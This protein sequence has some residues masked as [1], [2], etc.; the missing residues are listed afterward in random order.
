MGHCKEK[1]NMTSTR[2]LYVVFGLIYIV[3]P[4]PAILIKSS[5]TSHNLNILPTW[6]HLAYAKKHQVFNGYIASYSSIGRLP[7]LEIICFKFVNRII[8]CIN[9]SI[10]Q[11]PP[12]FK[13]SYF[14]VHFNLYAYLII[15][16]TCFATLYSKSA[17]F[18]FVRPDFAIFFD[19]KIRGRT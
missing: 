4:Y 17:S 6:H 14:Y 5:I 2:V 3:I 7:E 8:K 10:Y 13:F 1:R 15:F 18:C 12:S 9:F 11:F 16:S 19:S